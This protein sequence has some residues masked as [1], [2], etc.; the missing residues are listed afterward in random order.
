MTPGPA[1][2]TP[3]P[4]PQAPTPAPS[5]CGTDPPSAPLE[6][7]Q[8]PWYN[9]SLSEVQRSDALLAVLTPQEK[10]AVLAGRGVDR[11]L[12]PSDGFNEAL[13][14]VAWAGRATVFPCPMLLGA[15]FDD[16]LVREIGATVAREALAKHWDPSGSS[17]ALS[18]FAPNINI[19]RDVRWGRAQETY[20]EDPT[21]T[22]RM[23][24][25]YVQGMQFLGSSDTKSRLAVRNVAK[26]FAAYNLESNYAGRTTPA[27]IAQGVGQYRLQYDAHVPKA[28][29]LQTYLPAFEDVVRD[30]KIRGGELRARPL[31]ADLLTSQPDN[32]L[33]NSY[34]DDVVSSFATALHP[35]ASHV[36]I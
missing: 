6:L 26:H 18:F 9:S 1:L 8:C 13:H 36:R 25:A 12:V 4:T 15:T 32:M 23:G 17:N 5:G 20:G 34:S 29:L 19:V 21:L 16:A 2:P 31:A 22:G 24:V 10:L 7:P 27:Q 14:G 30:A 28:D 33:V 35:T 11:L 3:P